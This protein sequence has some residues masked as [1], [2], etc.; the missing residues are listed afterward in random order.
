MNTETT[1]LDTWVIE[2]IQKEYPN[3]VAL[4]IGHNAYRLEEDKD[5]AS[6]SYYFPLNEKGLGLAKTFI[7]DGVGYDLFPMS[8]ERI[9]RMAA[10][11][12]DNASVIADAVILYCRTEEDSQKF[13][14]VQDRLQEH[15]KDRKYMVYK[16]LEKLDIA[17]GL[18]QTM[19][20]EET[21]HKLRKNA[22]FIMQYLANAVA[23]SN[24]T[25]FGK[26]PFVRVEDIE[27]LP[28]FPDN[29]LS[30]FQA[31]PA[32]SSAD[33][34]REKCFLIIRNTREYLTARKIQVK[35]PVA[36]PDF[37]QLAD[38]Y[39]ELSYAWRQIERWGRQ[40]DVVKTFIRSSF[41][42]NEID[43]IDE[44]FRLGEVDL[45]GFFKAG[46]LKAY[47]KHTDSVEGQI[48]S[49]IEENGGKIEAYTSIEAFL[50][51]NR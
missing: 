26:A 31:I 48:T 7:I 13:I 12:E 23:Y 32:A 51:K 46:D 29:F 42:Q 35:Q 27:K 20:F 28:E 49:R 4:L 47:L 34:L 9:G 43:S 17:M 45:L 37:N 41:L 24:Q 10:F 22:G 25:F 30:L 14:S 44:E 2:K 6:F 39:C 18:Y 1:R 11:D 40:G 21:A 16:A 19:L 5:K 15:L 33:E 50:E 8:W 38:W 3:D 36:E